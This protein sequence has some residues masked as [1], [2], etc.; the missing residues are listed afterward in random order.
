MYH[1]TRKIMHS[2]IHTSATC[3]RVPVMRAHSEAVWVETEDVLPPS[4][5]SAVDTAFAANTGQYMI[6]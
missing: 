5:L 2:D 3:V 1:E 6:T 4:H